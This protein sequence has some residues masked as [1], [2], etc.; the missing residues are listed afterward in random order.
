MKKILLIAGEVSGDHHA[1]AMLN[2]LNELEEIEAFG[3]GGDS[4]QAAG[5]DLTFHIKE[6]AF[7]GIGEVIKHLPF[8]RKV[9][10]TLLDKAAAE[11]PDAVVMIDYPGFNLR[12]AKAAKKLNIPVIYY[13][14]P[15]VWAWGKNRVKKIRKY[16]DKLLVIFPFERDF[17]G[18]Y[19]IEAEYV[20][21]PIVDN[22]FP[23]R[24]N[25]ENGYLIKRKI[26][27]L[28]GSRRQ[29]VESLLPRMIEAARILYK[30]GKI[31]KAVIVKV[32]NI[33]EE[34]YI[35]YLN[36]NDTFIEIIERPLNETLPL[37]DAA[38]IASGTAT[39]EA[40]Y[41]GLPMVIVYQVNALTYFFG[42]LMVKLPNIGLVNIVAG[43]EVAREL[44]QSD[45]TAEAAAKEIE[46]LLNPEKNLE[47]RRELV[48]IREKL[49]DPGASKRAAQHI[50]SFL[51]S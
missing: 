26:G 3:I 32:K 41:Y 51:N 33:P 9:Y 27:L 44:I 22:D 46:I 4:L 1:A 29:E 42:K 15:Q 48:V 35:H 37:F 45:F 12:F 25:I 8:I 50:L 43:K 13:I 11:R 21:H 7:H 2:R 47:M 20:G 38:I 16:V 36:N 14:T 24:E 23:Q 31:E 5:M 19:K 30:S 28:P 6:M 10:H 34:K 40:G 18:R 39:L 17:Y 49:G